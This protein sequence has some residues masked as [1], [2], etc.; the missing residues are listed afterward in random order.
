YLSVI[1]KTA[2]EE[3]KI[4]LARKK[5]YAEQLQDQIRL[6]QITEFKG[7]GGTG[8]GGGQMVTRQ[9]SNDELLQTRME[10]KGIQDEIF[11]TEKTLESLGAYTERVA[12]QAA[13]SE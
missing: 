9:L 7:A 6:Q 5:K 4:E 3:G 2:I 1:N 13:M 8:G 10:L 11:A 12:G